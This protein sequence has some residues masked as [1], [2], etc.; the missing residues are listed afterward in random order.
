MIKLNIFD[1]QLETRRTGDEIM[2]EGAF[3]DLVSI[4]NKKYAAKK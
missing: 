3:G 2:F 1:E 4:L